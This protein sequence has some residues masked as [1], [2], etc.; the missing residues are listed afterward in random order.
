MSEARQAGSAI[1]DQARGVAGDLKQ[2]LAAQAEA[3]KDSFAD[4]L[5]AIADQVHGTAEQLRGREAWVA[6]L[7][8]RGARELGHVAEDLKHRDLRA[9]TRSFEGFARR[10]PALF[11]GTAVALGFALTRVARS[12]GDA[13]GRSDQRYGQGY[14]GAETGPGAAAGSYGAGTGSYGAG[15]YGAGASG[16]YVDEPS[17]RPDLGRSWPQQGQSDVSAGARGVTGTTG[18]AAGSAGSSTTPTDSATAAGDAGRTPGTLGSQT[19]ST[20]DD[21][22][23]GS[24][25]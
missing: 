17:G 24:N 12:G 10:Q 3:Q 6:D 15:G 11:M 7:I 5:Q 19:G 2:Q 1:K 9:L 4:R 21:V 25:V 23:R 16:G 14:R 13:Y 18:G 8:D 22:V 20:P